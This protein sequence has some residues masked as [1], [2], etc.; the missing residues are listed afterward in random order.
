[1][2]ASN[3]EPVL[4]LQRRITYYINEEPYQQS[5]YQTKINILLLIKLIIS[6]NMSC[7]ERN[8]KLT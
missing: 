6:L 1:V 3:L 8:F 7:I 2:K 5:V 4:I